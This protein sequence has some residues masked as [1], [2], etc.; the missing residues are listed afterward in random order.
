[1]TERVIPAETDDAMRGIIGQRVEL[2]G[3]I[4]SRR[5]VHGA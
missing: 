3:E 4:V 5:P 2:R 1:V